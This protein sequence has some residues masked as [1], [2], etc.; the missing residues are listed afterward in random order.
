MSDPNIVDCE[1]FDAKY[2]HLGFR[3]RSIFQRLA[4]RE[5]YIVNITLPD[6]TTM[7]LNY[8]I[9]KKTDFETVITEVNKTKKMKN[10]YFEI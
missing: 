1:D 8:N 6:N 4:G 7:K 3:S 10:Y 5:K 2:D 9:T